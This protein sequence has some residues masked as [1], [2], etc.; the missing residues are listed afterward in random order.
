MRV[1]VRE[2]GCIE[3]DDNDDDEYIE[4]EYIWVDIDREAF[5]RLVDT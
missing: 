1:S 3:V 4:V 5:L 2:R